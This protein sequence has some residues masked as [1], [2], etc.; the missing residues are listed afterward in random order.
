MVSSL[1]FSTK[2]LILI[3]KCYQ[4]V[5]SPFLGS[6]CRFNPVCSQYGIEVLFRFGCIKGIWLI[7]KRILKCHPLHIGGDDS[8]SSRYVNYNREN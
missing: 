1:S 5:I 7:I 3:I 2:I 4:L 6:N 8:V